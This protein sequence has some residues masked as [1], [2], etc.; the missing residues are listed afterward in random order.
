MQ[1]LQYNPWLIHLMIH[2][3][4]SD[5]YSPVNAFL[6]VGGNPFPDRA[7]LFI[8]ADLFRYQFTRL[9]DGETNW[10]TREYQQA[11]SPVFTLQSSQI[12]S[13]LR[14]MRWKAPTIPMRSS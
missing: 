7:P 14:Q 11:Y 8:K 12:K 5:Q 13:I 6:T 3:L 2:L 10:W 1:D 9:N 4:A